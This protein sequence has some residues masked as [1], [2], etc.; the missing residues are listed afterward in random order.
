MSLNEAAARLVS[1]DEDPNG[2]GVLLMFNEG[3]KLVGV[4][5]APSDHPNPY[6]LRGQKGSQMYLVSARMFCE[7]F[8]IPTEQARRYRARK[9]EDGIVGFALDDDYAKVGRRKKKNGNGHD[10]GDAEA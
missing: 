8:D 5:R 1:G 3:N 10:E 2:V 9:L 4:K 6:P 7:H